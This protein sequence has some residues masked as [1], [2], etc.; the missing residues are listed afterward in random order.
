MSEKT[1]NEIPR[2]LRELFQKGMAALQRQNYEYAIVFFNQVLA[3][4]PGFFDGRQSLR[5]A[6]FKKSGGSTSFF[7]KVFGGA[8]PNLAKAKLALQKNPVEAL[9]ILEQILNSDPANAAAHRMVAE[10][11]LV[12]DFPRT[13]CLSLEILL[14]GSTK[15]FELAMQYAEALAR[16]GQIPKAE[17]IYAE[18]AR[19]YPDKPEVQQGLKDLSAKRT[20]QEGG[21]DSLADGS[22]SYRDI[23]KDKDEAVALEQEKR[24]VKTED[25]ASRLIGEYEARLAHEPNNLKLLRNIAELYTQKHQFDRALEYYRRI[26][27]AGA[28]ADASLEKAIA[29]TTLRKFDHAIEGLDANAPDYAEQLARLQAERTEFRLSECRARVERYP[30]DL[31]FRYELGSMLFE[32]GKASEAI[33]ELQKAQANPQRKLQAMNLLAQCFAKRGMNDMAARKLQEALREKQVFD[34]EKKEM[35]YNLGCVLE[36]MGK[37]EEAIEQFKQIY[38][39][40][41]GYRDVGAKVDAY[42]S[43]RP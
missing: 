25:V 13:A 31:Q 33:Q 3:R 24:E 38:E 20:L 1:I 7:K 12:A 22:G 15:D 16:C 10:A 8:N 39:I 6:Q 30:T 18:L 14:K 41:I 4:E 43:N 35:I 23:L 40:D 26:Q 5:A 11:A 19:Q 9:G 42:Y 27:N 29:E 32:A 36:S 21:Y 2:D 17:S 28:G 34:D 37:T